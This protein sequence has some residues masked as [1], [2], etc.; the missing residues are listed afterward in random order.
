[1]RE[2]EVLIVTHRRPETLKLTIASV[3]AEVRRAAISAHIKILLNG[4]DDTSR[5]WLRAQ[6]LE[7]FES[8]ITLGPSAAR[9]FLAK[10]SSAPWVLFLDDDCVLPEQ[11]FVQFKKIVSERIPG[12][13]AIGGPNLTPPG[14]TP[15]EQA[16]GQ[17]LGHSFASLR[18]AWRYRENEEY[19]R[20]TDVE[21]TSTHLFV[22]AEVIAKVEFPIEFQTAEE[23]AFLHRVRQ[24][25]F[26]EIY[27]FGE[28][29]VYHERRK[30]WL[31]FAWQIFRYGRGRGQMVRD[32]FSFSWF[33]FVPAALVAMIVGSLFWPVATIAIVYGVLL[34]LYKVALVVATLTLT[35]AKGEGEYQAP[36][37][38]PL[39]FVTV[40][41][42]Y[43]LGWWW[44]FVARSSPKT[45]ST[46]S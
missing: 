4:P 19:F 21:L 26:H 1:M 23:N 2:L 22:R 17:V 36:W 24:A 11:F 41:V 5:E 28:L 44:G 32:G 45:E 40:H 14:A 34:L 13:Q 20:C 9:N 46:L 33:H 30:T 18:S 25:G 3:T 6:S 31:A 42:A 12:A 7:Y 29:F 10:R 37:R 35:K 15:F 16:C 39:L 8:P 43:V 38:A 27:Y